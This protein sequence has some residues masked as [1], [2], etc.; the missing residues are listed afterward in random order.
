MV[1]AIP[2]DP[3]SEAE[4]SLLGAAFGW[5][6]V[7]RSVMLHAATL[8][9]LLKNEMVALVF[10]QAFGIYLTANSELRG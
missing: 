6:R 4:A 8:A 7:I 2:S 10:L 1:P 5:A 9:A 3:R